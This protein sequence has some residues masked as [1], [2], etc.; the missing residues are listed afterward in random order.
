MIPSTGTRVSQTIKRSSALN[1]TRN[2][3]GLGYTLDKDDYVTKSS[4]IAFMATD[5]ISITSDTFDAFF[6]EIQVNGDMA[7]Y[8]TN[9]TFASDTAWTKGTG[10]TIAGDV[11]VA[12]GGIST[13]IS[14][15]IATL[16]AGRIYTV[17]YTVSG[18]SAGT[19]TVS[20]GGT[21]GAARASDATFTEAIVCG[22]ANTTLAF[23]GVAFTGNIDNV[24]V[25]AWGLG[26]G[27]AQNGTVQTATTA[28]TAL[29]QVLSLVPGKSYRVTYTTTR[30]AGSVQ[31]S[32]GGTAGTARSTAATFTDYILA[33]S[34]NSLLSFTGTGF[35]GTIDNVVVQ[36][37]SLDPGFQ[38]LVSGSSLNNRVWRV[39]EA[40]PTTLKVE[41]AL[42]RAENAGNPVTVR[43]I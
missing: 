24:I 10:W 6:P 30:T 1:N 2:L 25:T 36:Q 26:T 14:Q 17:T 20:V 13:A 37:M 40:S 34:T 43:A 28:D 23:T 27:W 21:A 8:V 38:I 5:T 19:V 29:S 9:G 42:V 11:G 16:E 3:Q 15:N 18:F 22:S 32:L 33:G 41:P 35:S 39:V 31:V 4:N 12:T 7:N